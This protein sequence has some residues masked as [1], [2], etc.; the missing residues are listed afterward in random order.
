MFMLAIQ[1]ASFTDTKEAISS[2]ISD[3]FRNQSILMTIDNTL[4][5]GLKPTELYDYGF[6]SIKKEFFGIFNSIDN[7]IGDEFEYYYPIVQ[8]VLEY[9]LD[10]SVGRSLIDYARGGVTT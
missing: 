9:I 4:Y 1:D 7:V 10:Y 6:V 8:D 5:V 2:R 3:A